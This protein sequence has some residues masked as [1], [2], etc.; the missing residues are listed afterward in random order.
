MSVA[1]TRINNEPL[2]PSLLGNQK[3]TNVFSSRFNKTDGTIFHQITDKTHA[4]APAVLE[5][6]INVTTRHLVPA[7][8]PSQQPQKQDD[9]YA[10]YTHPDKNELSC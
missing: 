3:E 2:S 5:D 4:V 6:W 7:E 9:A 1:C 10:T 8:L